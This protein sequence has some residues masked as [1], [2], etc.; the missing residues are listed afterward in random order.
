M[1]GP[2]EALLLCSFCHELLHNVNKFTILSHTRLILGIK[3]LKSYLRPAYEYELETFANTKVSTAK[4]HGENYMK[5][6]PPSFA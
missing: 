6:R 1:G 3:G 5:V 4:N 2:G